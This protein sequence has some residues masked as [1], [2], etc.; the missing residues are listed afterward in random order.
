M[1]TAEGSPDN[2]GALIVL[3]LPLRDSPLY[4]PRLNR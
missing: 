1:R 3:I 4:S 2:S